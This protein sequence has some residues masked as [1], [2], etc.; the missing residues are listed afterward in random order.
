MRKSL[1][2]PFKMDR[3]TMYRSVYQANIWTPLLSKL[4]AVSPGPQQMLEKIHSEMMYS[5]WKQRPG[6]TLVLCINRPD[7]T[8]THIKKEL[9]DD[10]LC[11]W[12][13]NVCLTSFMVFSNA[14]GGTWRF[15]A[16]W[17]SEWSDSSRSP[18]FI[19]LRFLTYKCTEQNVKV[20][21]S[22]HYACVIHSNDITVNLT[23]L[24]HGP[25]RIIW[26]F[27]FFSVFSFI[28]GSHCAAE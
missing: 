5:G 26:P 21:I 24:I 9:N 8:I 19:K 14:P 7:Y 22:A 12:L 23:E 3:T 1:K 27:G 20:L 16:V 28:A 25:E 2:K 6:V 11:I 17:F 4:T 18:W 15:T 10:A 13:W